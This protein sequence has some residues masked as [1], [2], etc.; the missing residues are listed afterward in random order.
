[1]LWDGQ[2]T[3]WFSNWGL[4]AK[5]GSAVPAGEAPLS[6]SSVKS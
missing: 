4:T 6:L 2:R 5:D 1:M 3:V